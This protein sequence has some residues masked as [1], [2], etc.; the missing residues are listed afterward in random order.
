MVRNEKPSRE[1][2]RETLTDCLRFLKGSELGEFD[3]ST[4]VIV[5]LGLDSQHG[6][7][8][9]CDLSSRLKIEIPLKEN[10]LIEDGADGRMRSRTFGE[11]LE[12]LVAL[13]GE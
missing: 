9:A 1:T 3:E 2:I 7:E 12:Y 11:V 13:A 5:G 8:L 4:D 6:V 10:P